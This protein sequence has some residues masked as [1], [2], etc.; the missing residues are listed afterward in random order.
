[1]V[2]DRVLSSSTCADL[3]IHDTK[4]VYETSLMINIQQVE[5]YIYAKELLTTKHTEDQK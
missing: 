5:Y 2:P 4:N 1:M 3:Y